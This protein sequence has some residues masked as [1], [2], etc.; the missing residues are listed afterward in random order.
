VV[1]LAQVG[2]FNKAKQ[3]ARTI[4]IEC[5]RLQAMSELAVGLTQ[6]GYT[7]DADA[8]FIETKAFTEAKNF[9][10][11]DDY[12]IWVSALGE[13][14]V[15]LAKAGHKA[16][17]DKVFTKAK[18]AAAA[19]LWWQRERT[20][21]KL[22]SALAQAGCFNE[23]GKVART[24]P[25]GKWKRAEALSMLAN[26]LA[27]VAQT[28]AARTIFTEARK[29]ASI[30]ND[31]SA[32]EA[33]S[34]LA[35]VLAKTGYEA[36]AEALFIKIREAQHTHEDDYEQAQILSALA[37]ALAQAGRF[38][39]AEEVIDRISSENSYRVKALSALALALEKYGQTVEADRVFTEAQKAAHKPMLHTSLYALPLSGLV[40]A[41]AQV[42]RL[43]EAMENAHDIND[44]LQ[45]VQA[46]SAVASALA[47]AGCMPQA[48]KVFTQAYKAA[49]TIESYGRW[50]GAI[51]ALA[52]ALS[53]A[54]YFN[55]AREVI[56]VIQDD[57]DRLE[58][59]SGLAAP[60]AK[61]GRFAGAL[62]TLGL[63]RIDGFL[64]E[65][66]EWAAAFE[67]VNPG[68]SVAVL[69]EVVRIAGWVRPG[70]REIYELLPTRATS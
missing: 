46:L 32:I 45:K 30:T 35:A 4:E 7:A 29:A 33:I 47:N 27:E 65:L 13:L 40:T 12:E 31:S 66:T 60:L 24:I 9:S 15:A 2:H 25:E 67:Q 39:D 3:V 1:T 69:R 23:A 21:C 55:K 18:E 53:Q 41:L 56:Q 68:L 36:E 20:L 11:L 58:A 14:A 61:T 38:T 50:I 63:Q 10:D 52:A 48:E 70:W 64:C 51:G 8:I 43:N 19:S 34:N 5:L 28:K 57:R 16:D 59:L 49:Y 54:G 6:A 37:V 62:D 26:V 42:G 44:D 22:S 17:A